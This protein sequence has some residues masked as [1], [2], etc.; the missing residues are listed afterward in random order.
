MKIDADS[1]NDIPH[2]V[3]GLADL[4]RKNLS[5]SADVVKALNATSFRPSTTSV[6][7]LREYNQG[8]LL[9]RDG[10]TLEAQKQFEA[11]TKDDPTFALAYSKLAQTYASLG[12]DSDAEIDRQ[13]SSGLEPEPARR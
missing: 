13:K 10:K 2:T 9:Q 6:P 5:V 11:A 4:I 7:A 8:L 12:Y 1:E 3:D